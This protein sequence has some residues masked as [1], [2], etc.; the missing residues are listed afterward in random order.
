MCDADWSVDLS[1]AG[2]CI[3]VC[4]IVVAFASKKMRCVAL[5]S[6]EAE[7]VAASMAAAGI[8]Y[9]RSLLAHLGFVVAQPTPLAVDNTGPGGDLARPVDA[10]LAV[11]HCR[12]A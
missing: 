8:V 1:T 11:K 2:W 4:G 6:T 3:F 12:A 10:Q 9:I 7:L 5:S